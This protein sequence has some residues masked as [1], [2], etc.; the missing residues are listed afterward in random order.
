ME[1]NDTSVI[2]FEHDRVFFYFKFHF[3]NNK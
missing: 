3:L 1:L 2:S